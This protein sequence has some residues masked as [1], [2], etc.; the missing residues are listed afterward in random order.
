MAGS[1]MSKGRASSVTEASPRASRRRIARRVG[2]ERAEK[3]VSSDCEEYLTIWLII[4]GS[5]QAVKRRREETFE[6]VNP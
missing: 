6:Y 1:D 2:S 5:P 4:P 3:I